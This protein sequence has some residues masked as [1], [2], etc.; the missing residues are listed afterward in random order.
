[1]PPY[2]KEQLKDSERYQTVWNE[3]EGSVAAPTAS[4]HFTEELIEKIKNK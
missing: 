1:M 3:I 2:I 4:L